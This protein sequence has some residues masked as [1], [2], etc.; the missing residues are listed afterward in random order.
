[1]LASEELLGRLSAELAL[2]EGDITR[3]VDIESRAISPLLSA[4]TFI[5]FA[6]RF[7]SLIDALP[8][9]NKRE[10]QMRQLKS[11]LVNVENVRNHLQ[12]M[13][14]DLSSN[15]EIDYPILGSLMWSNGDWAY[16]IFLS[17]PTQT[18]TYSM[19]YDLANQRWVARYQYRVKNTI[20]DLENVLATM[21]EVYEWVVSKAQFSDPDFALPRW[22][23]TQAFCTRFQVGQRLS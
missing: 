18:N 12:H 7:G 15:E 13:R 9:L 17:Q 2:L 21:K 5:D 3:S 4:V 10:S 16:T 19:V 11:A 1:M 6:H 20:V 14:G 23:K 8:L 22:G